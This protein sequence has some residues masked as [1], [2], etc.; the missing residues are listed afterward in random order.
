MARFAADT[1]LRPVI[2]KLIAQVRPVVSVQIDSI[3]TPAIV[4][5]RQRQKRRIDPEVSNSDLPQTFNQRT[6]PAKMR[7]QW[8]HQTMQEATPRPIHVDETSGTEEEHMDIDHGNFTLLSPSRASVHR[9]P[10][11]AIMPP[12]PVPPRRKSKKTKKAS[13]SESPASVSSPSTHFAKLSLLSP[14]VEISKMSLDI[15][16]STSTNRPQSPSPPTSSSPIPTAPPIKLHTT[17]ISPLL[18]FTNLPTQPPVTKPPQ[19]SDLLTVQPPRAEPPANERPARS[20]SPHLLGLLPGLCRER[21][22]EPAAIAIQELPA[23]AP[24]PTNTESVHQSTHDNSTTSQTHAPPANG[25]R[26][27]NDPSPP[28]EL[29]PQQIPD[30]HESTN[31]PEPLSSPPTTQSVLQVAPEDIPVVDPVAKVEQEPE[32]HP[33]PP[34]PAREASPVPQKVK[35]S[36]KDFLMRK[37]KEQVESPVI[38]SSTIPLPEPTPTVPVVPARGPDEVVNPLEETEEVAKKPV[39]APLEQLS[40]PPVTEP[41]DVDVDADGPPASEPE[42]VKDNSEVAQPP[43]TTPDGLPESWL[44]DPQL[45]RTGLVVDLRQ[46]QTQDWVHGEF[47]GV[48]GVIES[49]VNLPGRPPTAL[50][51]PIGGKA[52]AIVIPVTTMIPVR[53]SEEGEVVIILSGQHKAK[54]GKVNKLTKDIVSIDLDGAETVAVEV[55]LR[56]LCLFFRE[57]RA[58]LP[59]PLHPP[60]RTLPEKGN[61]MSPSPAPQSEDGEIPQDPLPRGQSQQS[62]SSSLPQITTPLR[63]AP[64]NAPTQPRSFQNAWKNNTSPAIPSR[65]NSLSHLINANPNGSVNGNLNNLSNTFVNSPNRPG[66][67]SGPKALRGLNPRTPFDGSRYKPGG[68]G[69]GL[70]GGGMGVLPGMNGSGIGVGLKRELNPNNGHP[71]IPKGPSADRERERERANGNWSTK[72][73]GSGWR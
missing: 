63:A 66:P 64:L 59:S 27:S 16:S 53:P 35:T 1:V 3:L 67:P 17:P 39:A 14:T 60:P 71:A 43:Q 28:R 32:R 12:P 8:I 46:D 51:K 23:P 55:E 42:P 73:W 52:H 11:S 24:P 13:A 61:S 47:M 26:P 19:V 10:D 20:A 72:N 44:L 22:E 69:S 29:P 31:T 68:M 40:G 9:V 57:G 21:N 49:V 41:S 34:P 7:K 15:A 50:F 58:P 62:S 54:V 30:H 65:P 37:K 4:T 25:L 2:R 56:R 48:H 45:L 18:A 70:N 5:P 6:V 36:F 38:P 33:T